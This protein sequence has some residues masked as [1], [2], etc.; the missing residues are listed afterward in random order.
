MGYGEYVHLFL[1]LTLESD[2]SYRALD[3]IQENLRMDYEDSFRVN[4]CVWEISYR[5]DGKDYNYAYE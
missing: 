3:L 4:R 5:V 2:K 1:F